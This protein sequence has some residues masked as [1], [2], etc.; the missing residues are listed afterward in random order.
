MARVGQWLLMLGCIFAAVAC[1]GF[2]VLYESVHL[3]LCGMGCIVGALIVA[4]KFKVAE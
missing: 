3:S 4:P 2:G 1:F